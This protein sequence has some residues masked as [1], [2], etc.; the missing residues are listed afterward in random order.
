[1]TCVSIDVGTPQLVVEWLPAQGAAAESGH[2]SLILSELTGQV[3]CIRQR[4]LRV[5]SAAGEAPPQLPLPWALATTPRCC[6]LGAPSSS[7]AVH[8]QQQGGLITLSRGAAR[9]CSTPQHPCKVWGQLLV[10]AAPQPRCSRR[11]TRHA[12]S[13]RLQ[14][15]WCC[16]SRGGS[17]RVP[18]VGDGLQ[19]QML[20]WRQQNGSEAGEAAIKFPMPQSYGLQ[21]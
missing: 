9:C 10:G 14:E 7:P 1:M 5:E 16:N 4:T 8:Q 17:V 21:E 12:T 2:S 20:Q 11:K 13:V 6:L 15:C 19:Q 3:K 18:S